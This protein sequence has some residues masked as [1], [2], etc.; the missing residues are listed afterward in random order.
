M[1]RRSKVFGDV[2]KTVIVING[3]GGVGKD[4]LCDFAAKKF[5]IRNVSSIDPVKEVARKAGWKGE[6]T[7]EARKF[8]S[9]LKQI[10][11]TYNDAPTNYLL[12]HLDKFAKNREKI[13]FA[14]IREPEEIQKFKDRAELKGWNVMTLLIRRKTDTE[15]WGNQSDD[16]VENYTYDHIY[17]NDMPLDEAEEYFIR[18]LV[19]S[20]NEHNKK[21]S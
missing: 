4:T 8:L 19:W 5:R 12:D 7:P 11:I 9:D 17:G 1:I 2:D 14:H 6:K 10:M 20:I 13:M 18:Y 21:E 16:E 15:Q 3:R